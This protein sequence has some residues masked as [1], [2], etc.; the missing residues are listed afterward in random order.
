MDQTFRDHGNDQIPLAAPLRRDDVIE[1]ELL[2][3]P[4]NGFNL[5][6]GQRLLNGNGRLRRDQRFTAKYFSESLDLLFR[7]LREIG[8]GPLLY[9]SPLSPRFPQKNRRL[10]TAIRHPLNMHDHINNTLYLFYQDKIT[11]SMTTH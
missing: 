6:V 5:A 7:P 11:I 1:P 2:Y 4:E 3:R 10:P 9:L 8:K